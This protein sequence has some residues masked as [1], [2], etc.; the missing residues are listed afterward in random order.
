MLGDN[1]V[2]PTIGVSD[3]AVA[4]QFYELMLGL[5]PAYENSEAGIVCYR[6]G[7]GLVQIYKTDNAGTNKATYA[8]WEVD[9][10]AAA[11][12]NLKAKGVKFERYDMPDTEH[13]GDLHI[14]GEDIAAWF[15]D[16]DGN[17]LCLHQTGAV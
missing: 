7:N 11:V 2:M 17:V 3:L 9:D 13:D 16:P 4:R 15:K 10:V 6:S 8:S 5:T 14:W 1:D 12:D